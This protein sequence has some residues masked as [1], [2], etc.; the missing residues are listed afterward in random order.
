[1]NKIFQEFTKGKTW[2]E[3]EEHGIKWKRGTRIVVEF[4]RYCRILQSSKLL[5][6]YSRERSI[7]NI[8]IQKL[9]YGKNACN[10]G[11]R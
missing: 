3:E 4:R 6:E 10:A 7:K 2:N 8:A 9:I 1:M 5:I 11:E